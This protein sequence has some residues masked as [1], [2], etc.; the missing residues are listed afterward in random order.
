MAHL[1][2][3]EIAIKDYAKDGRVK[4]V[5]DN[6]GEQVGAKLNASFPSI[7]EQYGLSHAEACVALGMAYAGL[8][9]GSLT[10]GIS[11]STE[12]SAEQV[13]RF[14]SFLAGDTVDHIGMTVLNAI[15]RFEV[16]E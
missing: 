7:M 5:S 1:N 8:T 16:G 12:L 15:N 4:Q 14:G 13:S 9:A 11:Q 3:M 6:I 10:S 2:A